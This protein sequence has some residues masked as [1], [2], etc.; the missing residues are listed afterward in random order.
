MLPSELIYDILDLDTVSYSVYITSS[1]T[2]L[3]LDYLRH[4]YFVPVT[5]HFQILL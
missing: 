2:H 4:G 5:L 1:Q 3:S